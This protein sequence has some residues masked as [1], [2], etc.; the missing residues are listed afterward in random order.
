MTRLTKSL[1]F[2]IILMSVIIYAQSDAY[3][4]DKPIAYLRLAWDT[5]LYYLGFLD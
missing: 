4:L 3:F 2:I 5:V 1:I